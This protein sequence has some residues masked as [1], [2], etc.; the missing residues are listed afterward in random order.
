MV[1]PQVLIDAIISLA[2]SDNSRKYSLLDQWIPD[3]TIVRHLSKDSTT[4]LDTGTF[5]RTL[6]RALN[7]LSER[8]VLSEEFAL[9]SNKRYIKRSKS[10]EKVT[11]VQFYYICKVTAMSEIIVPSVTSF[12]QQ[13]WE[14]ALL[15]CQRSLKRTLTVTSSDTIS[16]RTKAKTTRES[17]LTILY[18]PP[19][20]SP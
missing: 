3:E 13:A 4:K 8:Q 17:N 10:N 2:K 6:Q 9:L 14:N 11:N 1:S 16:R 5:N 7:G 18:S 20:A 19:I 12:Y 15:K